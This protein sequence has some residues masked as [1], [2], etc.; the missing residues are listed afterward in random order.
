M[1][2]TLCARLTSC[3]HTHARTHV[4]SLT[5]SLIHSLTHPPTRPPARPPAR[6]L[7]HSRGRACARIHAHIHTRTRRHEW[8]RGGAMM[9]SPLVSEASAATE[10][11][12]RS[13]PPMAMAD[14]WW[15]AAMEQEPPRLRY[16]SSDSARR[17]THPTEQLR[18]RQRGVVDGRLWEESNAAARDE[19]YW[20]ARSEQ[21]QAEVRWLHSKM[22]GAHERL[23]AS[24]PRRPLSPHRAHSPSPLLRSYR[25]S[26]PPL[27]AERF[28]SPSAARTLESAPERAPS[29]WVVE[30]LA[31]RLGPPRSFSPTG[32]L[33]AMRLGDPELDLYRAEVRAWLRAGQAPTHSPPGWEKYRPS[34]DSVPH[35]DTKHLPET[36]PPTLQRPE[37]TYSLL[38]R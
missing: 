10:I 4:H 32:K 18:S 25:D 11:L 5:H 24:P 28:H 3:V 20:R 33:D 35:R 8:L 2:S 13:R 16:G 29:K 9:P 1:R 26:V 36:S 37:V 30:Q 14:R 17:N 27:L 19:E 22:S 12:L 6:S 21:A 7:I 31:E 23:A 38:S 34:W 15:Q